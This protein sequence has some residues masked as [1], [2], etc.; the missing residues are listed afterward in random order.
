M[1]RS[2]C[3]SKCISV[4]F[5]VLSH[6]YYVGLIIS[7]CPGKSWPSVWTST[8]IPRSFVLSGH[9]LSQIWLTF[10]RST[11]ALLL[12]VSWCLWAESNLSIIDMRREH[13]MSLH[14]GCLDCHTWEMC[15][16]TFSLVSAC[17]CKCTPT[18]TLRSKHTYMCVHMKGGNLHRS[19]ILRMWKE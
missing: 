9:K 11:L 4:D 2:M 16:Q 19:I 14:I 3:I 17:I 5:S 6:Y 15:R 13:M 1:R 8:F 10:L 7:R 18:F 12:R